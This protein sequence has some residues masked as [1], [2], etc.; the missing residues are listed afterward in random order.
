MPN[1][2]RG[3]IEACL[4]GKP[5]RLC[6]TLSALAELEHTFGHEDM[7]ALAERFQSGRLSARD[8]QR[9]IGAGLRGAGAEIADETV[10][11]MQTDGGAAGFVDI[12]AR[13]LSATFGGPAAPIIGAVAGEL[14]SDLTGGNK[15]VPTNAPHH[16]DVR[17]V[18]P[19]AGTKGGSDTIAP[20]PNSAGPPRPSAA[21]APST[22]PHGVRP[23]GPDTVPS[24]AHHHPGVRPV[25][26][27]AG[28]GHGS[29]TIA[30]LGVRPSGSDTIAPTPNSAGPPRPNT[31]AAS[32]TSHHGVRP[33]GSDT[34]PFPGT[35]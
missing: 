19:K 26:P 17:P 1:L 8:A 13:L 25:L 12:V 16:P 28:A 31:A 6:L 14:I 33:G 5:F 9:I 18:L 34:V 7:L 23:G 24:N 22:S 2:H 32:S 4:D 30:P 3:E 15:S 35:T 20:T 10:G 29:D 27:E 21:A 11:R